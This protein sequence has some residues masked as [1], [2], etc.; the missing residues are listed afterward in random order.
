M[1]PAQDFIGELLG[2]NWTA[3]GVAVVVASCIALTSAGLSAWAS[4]SQGRKTRKQAKEFADAQA[5]RDGERADRDDLV[6]DREQWWTRFT[7]AA[8]RIHLDDKTAEV[9]AQVLS[10]IE[11]VD[12]ITE[13]DKNLVNSVL[14][15]NIG[16]VPPALISEVANAQDNAG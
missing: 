9:A 6:K 8:E 2:P 5:T 10:S 12:W 11:A 16:S 13:E 3:Q 15:K 14:D 1:L 4:I 7:W